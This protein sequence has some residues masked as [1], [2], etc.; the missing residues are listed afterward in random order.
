MTEPRSRS[1][2]RPFNPDDRPFFVGFDPR[3]V[4]SPAFVV[5]RA[6]VEH[7]L[8]I[9]RSVAD[10]A[11]ARV[12]LALKAFALPEVFD[13]VAQYLDGACASGVYEARLAREELGGAVHTFAPA[14]TP[15]DLLTLLDT[16]DHLSFNSWAHW[17]HHR[18]ACLAAQ[19]HRD[20]LRFGI[21]IN[22]EHSVGATAIYDPCAPY[23]RLGTTAD[24]LAADHARDAAPDG[25]RWT[26]ISG[27]HLHTLCENDSV[28]LEETVRAVEER[29]GSVLRRPEIRWLNLGG[30]HH[31]TKPDY[32][33]DHLVRIIRRLRR[34]YN[35][36]VILEPG[37]AIAIHTGVLV[38][39]V[40]DLPINR[41]PLAILDTS[42]TAHMPDVLEMPYRPAVWGAA[43]P[44]SHPYRYRL[45][46]QT[47]LAGDVIGDYS[48]AEPLAIGDRLVFDDMSHYTM[49]KT[50]TFNGIPLPTIVL[51]DSRTGSATTVRRPDYRD[52]R[53]RLGARYR[54]TAEEPG[55]TR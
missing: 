46:G 39:S 6:A 9:L 40:V 34:E 27:L 35:L 4:P 37:E 43:D 31:I 45:G 24:Q 3:T 32:D 25:D 18:D 21:R 22:P 42:A 53:D 29:F 17:L 14:Y 11:G 20:N 1:D 12:L 36:D 10:A 26:G 5:D 48:F 19:R 13:L 23:S 49:V 44:I 50:T 33:R 38:A 15:D 54:G 55:G 16:T 8:R 7:N 2:P 51:W 41:M 47:C 30:G 52:F 28:A